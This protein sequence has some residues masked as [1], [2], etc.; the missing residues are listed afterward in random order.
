MFSALAVYTGEMG[1]EILEKFISEDIIETHEENGELFAV[2]T[3]LLAGASIAILLLKDKWRKIAL[4]VFLV[5][6][7]ISAT[8]AIQAGSSGGDLIYKH[9]AAKYLTE[10]K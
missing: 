6:S 10:K 5:T 1:E 2:F 3:Y 4:Y 9:N 8:I 7:L